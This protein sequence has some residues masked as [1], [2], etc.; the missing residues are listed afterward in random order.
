[1]VYTFKEYKQEPLVKKH[2]NMGGKNPDGE[3]INVTSRYFMRAGPYK[4]KT[5]IRLGG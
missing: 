4:G 5:G 3:E 2:L 1:M